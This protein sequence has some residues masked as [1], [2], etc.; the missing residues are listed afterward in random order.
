MNECERRLIVI[1]KPTC[2]GGRPTLGLRLG[3][4]RR[5]R[6]LRAHG[7]SPGEGVQRPGV[8]GSRG[9]P[10]SRAARRR[11]DAAK[12]PGVQ[13]AGEAAPAAGLP[14]HFG[15]SGRHR[16]TL[17][18]LLRSARRA[19]DRLWPHHRGP[20]RPCGQDGAHRRQH[21]VPQT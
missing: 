17:A 14:Q 3:G 10:Q 7:L 4:G 9:A 16:R 15:A 8:A 1:K 18:H 21:D 19:S 5:L 13:G 12:L 2:A 20:Q 11:V 6:A